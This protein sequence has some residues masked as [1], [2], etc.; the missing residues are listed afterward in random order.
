MPSLFLLLSAACQPSQA[1]STDDDEALEVEAVETD[2]T[3]YKVII[4]DPF[5]EIHTGPSAG[6][7]IFH[8]IDRG[9]EVSIIRRK[10]NWFKIQT[11]DGKTGWASRDQMRETLLPG[12]EKFKV[13]ELD[14]EDFTS[15]KWI[16]GVTGGEFASAPVFT[17]FTGY[18]FTENLAAEVHFG[19][20]VG[21]ASSSTFIKANVVMQPLPDLKYS[22]YLT[23]GLGKIE[24]SSSAT[25]ISKNSEDDSFVQVGL[26]LQRYISRS[27][28]FRLEANEYVI[29][30][31]NSTSNSNE[32]VNE[33]K[34]GFAVFF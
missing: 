33:W 25:L 28:L 34:F 1:Q 8:V 12:G 24:I 13:V 21:N 4:T 26:G 15:R 30:S 7:P 5:I 2:N 22:P 32:V 6:Y 18:S 9:T 27:F 11:K 20:S 17:L 16:L 3:V 19:E 31:A 14:Q 23:L 10:T 29:F